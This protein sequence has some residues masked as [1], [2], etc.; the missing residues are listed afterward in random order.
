MS[1]RIKRG[2]WVIEGD[3]TDDLLQGLEAVE[4]WEARIQRKAGKPVEKKH[5]RQ[6][7]VSRESS[8]HAIAALNIVAEIWPKPMDTHELS[9]RL[10]LKSPKGIGAVTM[11][12]MNVVKARLPAGWEASEVLRKAKTRGK[13]MKLYVNPGPLAMLGLRVKSENARPNG[14]VEAQDPSNEGLAVLRPLGGS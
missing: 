12:M 3:T 14:T 2:S 6:E 7:P 5:S 13:P 1:T 9:R 4:C 11:A 8:E 10:G